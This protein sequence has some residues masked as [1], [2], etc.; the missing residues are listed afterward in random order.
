MLYAFKYRHFFTVVLLLTQLFVPPIYVHECNI[1]E[2]HIFLELVTSLK[3]II[4]YLSYNSNNRY[5][6]KGYKHII[7]NWT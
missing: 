5:I 3:T 1:G 6:Q 2:L 7:E 4:Q